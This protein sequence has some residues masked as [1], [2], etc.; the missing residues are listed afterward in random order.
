MLMPETP[1]HE[2]GFPAAC[3]NEV[4]FPRQPLSM[5][6]VMVSQRIHQLSDSHFWLHV[7]AADFPHVLAAFVREQPVYHE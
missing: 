6:P 3:K 7:L 2:N 5:Q 4:W 1:I